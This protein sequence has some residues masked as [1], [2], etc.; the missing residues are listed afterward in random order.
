M[1]ISR[2]KFFRQL[3]QRENPLKNV[4]TWSLREIQILVEGFYNLLRGRV[5]LF[6]RELQY[7]K[8]H[9]EAVGAIARC[10]TLHEGREQLAL[11][12]PKLLPSL[13]PPLVSHFQ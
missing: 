9:K 8:K 2:K 3:S 13:L 7:L 1:G 11:H 5:A 10:R 12:G 6:A 4:Q